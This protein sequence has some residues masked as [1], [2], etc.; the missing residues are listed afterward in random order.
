MDLKHPIQSLVPTLDGPVLEV[1][2][3]TTRA[4]T[5]RE[6]QRIADTASPAG[7]RRVLARLVEHG[8]VRAAEHS[9]AIFY[10]ANRDH[11]AWPAVEILVSMRRVLLDRIKVEIGSWQPTPI[12]ASLFG[13][14]AR[15]DGD[16]ESDIDLLIIRPS[17][18]DEDQSSWAEQVDTLRHNVHAWT[19]NQC[20]AFQINPE[21]LAAYVRVG[22]SIVDDWLRDAVDLFGTDLRTVVRQLPQAAEGS[23]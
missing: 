19:G 4:L 17:T 22:D 10:T 8:L 18:T 9:T 14:M 15:G 21:R 20:Q 5:G 23:E 16:A 6:I 13:S 2:A 11:L 7:V 12:H 1:L 3:G